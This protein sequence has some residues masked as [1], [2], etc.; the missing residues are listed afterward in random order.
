MILYHMINIRAQRLA[1]GPA[2]ERGP[3]DIAEGAWG[4]FRKRGLSS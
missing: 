2:G 4:R 1:T 3:A